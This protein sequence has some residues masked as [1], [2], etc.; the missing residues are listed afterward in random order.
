MRVGKMGTLTWLPHP[1][2][3]VPPQHVVEKQSVPTSTGCHAGSSTLGP[4][5][6]DIVTDLLSPPEWLLHKPEQGGCI[7]S[8]DTIAFPCS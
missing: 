7:H 1:H 3:I 5:E 8:S 6:M 4:G 2:N